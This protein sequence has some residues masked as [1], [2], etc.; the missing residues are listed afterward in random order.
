[1]TVITSWFSTSGAGSIGP[2]PDGAPDPFERL[3]ADR[4]SAD[5]DTAR[6]C[7]V[8]DSQAPIREPEPDHRDLAR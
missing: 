7:A 4:T 2:T 5:E 3:G 8:V 6:S 1:M